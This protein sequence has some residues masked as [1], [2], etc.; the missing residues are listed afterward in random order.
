VRLSISEKSVQAVIYLLLALL[1]FLCVYPF[2][3]T[4][5]ISFNVGMDTGKGGITFW[6]RVFT[7]DNYRIV[8]ADQKIWIGLLISVARTIVGTFFS[9]LVT[10]MLAYGLSKSNLVG[11]KTYMVLCVITLYFSGG[12]IPSYLVIRELGMF[13]TFW[14]LFVPTIV[15]VFNMIVFRTFFLSLP[16][17]LLESA[18]IDGCSQYGVFFRIAIPLSK[19]VFAAIGLFAAVYYWNEWFNASLYINKS[20][21]LPLQTALRNIINSNYVTERIGNAA[22]DDYFNNTNA[23]TSKSITMATMIIASVPIIILYPFLQKYFAKGVLIGS[24]KE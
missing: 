9:I 5:V 10:A 21:L 18:E 2:W 4:L 11:K 6:P 13:D 22:M 16:N 8:F 20:D 24:L 3:N 1:A 7:L 12:L 14:V 17:S 19:P 23:A 15:G